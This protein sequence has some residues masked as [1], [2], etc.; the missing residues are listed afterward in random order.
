[1]A[2]SRELLL[3]RIASRLHELFDGS[4]NLADVATKP[5][6]DQEQFFLT[7]A[8]TALTLL[9]EAELKPEQAGACVTDGG[10]DDGIDGVFVDEKDR[11][12]YFVQSKW[13][14]GSGGVQLNDFT[15]FRD[16]VKNILSLNWTD[17]NANLHPW[18][19]KIEASL[20]DIDTRIVML[21]SHTADSEIAQNIR[22]RI[23]DFL[24]EQ[25]KYLGDFLTFKEIDLAN[26]AHIAR[27][28][29]RATNID[30]SV[31]L[32]EWG[33]LAQPYRAVYGAV[34]AQ[35]IAKWFD[36]HGNKL[37]V[38]NLRFVIEKSDVNEGIME[39]A[40]TVPESFWYFN[41]GITAICDSFEKQPIGGTAT[42]SGVFDLKK[43]SVINGAQTIGSLG[44]AKAGGTNLENVYVHVRIISLV[45]T[46]EGFASGVTRSNNTQNNLNAVDFV[47]FDPNQDR[48][49]REAAQIG[50]VYSFRRGEAEPAPSDG[51]N[52]RSATVAAACASGDLRYA[53]SAKRYISG[54]WDNIKKEPYTKIFNSGT[55]AVYLWNI[56][57]IMNA[58]DEV[59]VA[60]AAELTGREKLI[61]VHANRF[62]LFWVF[63]QI[64]L[65][66]LA[67]ADVALEGVKVECEALALKCLDAVIGVIA[68]TLPDAYPGNIF[69]NQD[70]Q[71]ELLKAVG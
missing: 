36:D 56:V 37:F 14:S 51:F 28:R 42:S 27:S 31:L 39:T 24:A 46:P 57:R 55:T 13:R 21:L 62:I 3:G 52:V 69:K 34:S 18:K 54:L 11:A 58:V 10:T 4:I 33:L 1:M 45:G 30:L 7:R 47:S 64:D 16:G 35:D 17:E 41:N 61:A 25:N 9:D 50:L 49:R 22:T 6:A 15:R 23:N 19:E 67:A 2:D 20:K 53:V 65:A 44:R 66:A 8:L 63:Q 32:R 5:D 59:L 71:A 48:I 43:V 38:E 70:R 68:V 12:I 40:A 60:R 26:V 29:T